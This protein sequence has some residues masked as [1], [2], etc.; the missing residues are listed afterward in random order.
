MNATVKGFISGMLA[1]GIASAG[2]TVTALQEAQ[3]EAISDGAWVTIGLTGF[4]AAA[5][6]WRTLLTKPE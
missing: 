4:L 6:G 2:S 1:G 5:V 3:L